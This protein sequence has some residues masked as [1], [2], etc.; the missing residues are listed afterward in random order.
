MARLAFF[1]FGIL[2]RPY[3]DPST[4]DFMGLVADSFAQAEAS[5]G[6][7]DRSTIASETG[8]PSWGEYADSRFFDPEI[9]GG[10]PRTLSLWESIE[11][12]FAYAYAADHGEALKRRSEW[13]LKPEWPSQ[14][15]WWVGD[16]HTPDWFEATERHEY[17]HDNGASAF[18]FDVRN[19]YDADGNPVKVDRT[20]IEQIRKRNAERT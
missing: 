18:A 6:F 15:M 14:T 10:V 9:H 1:T 5:E 12:V 19:P 7:I 3:D 17:L 4:K 11:S 13:F 20:L 16:D 8:T 2:E